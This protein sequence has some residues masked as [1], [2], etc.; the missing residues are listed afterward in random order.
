MHGTDEKH[1]PEWQ[2]WEDNMWVIF[3]WLRIGTTF[4][5]L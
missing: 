5:F 4:G 1:N 3:V 2:R